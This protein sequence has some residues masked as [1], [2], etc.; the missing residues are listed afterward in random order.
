M[1]YSTPVEERY[2][3]YYV[4]FRR[5]HWPGWWGKFT[6]PEFQH[7]SIVEMVDYPPLSIHTE[8]C[9]GVTRQ[10]VRWRSPRN[11]MAKLLAD[12]S[13]SRIA[14]IKVEKFHRRRYIPFGMFT[15]VT[16]VKSILGV[17]DWRIQTPEQLLK[18]LEREGALII[19][20]EVS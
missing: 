17:H 19:G 18:Y 2:K 3:R 13:I 4:I 12:G 11:A 20:G 5:A 1:D 14:D 16:I 6:K 15:C 7:C 9:F 8:T 10:E